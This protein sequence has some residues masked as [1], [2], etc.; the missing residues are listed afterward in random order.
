MKKLYVVEVTYC[1]YVWAK[2]GANAEAFADYIVR[3]EEPSVESD[4]VTIGH[5]P[6]AWNRKR[7]VYHAEK[8]DI[9]LGEVLDSQTK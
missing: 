8:H 6:L 4:P 9:E 3:T 5:N 7:L 1:A 2:D